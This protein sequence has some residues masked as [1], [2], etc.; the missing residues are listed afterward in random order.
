MKKPFYVIL[1]SLMIA[2]ALVPQFHSNLDSSLRLQSDSLSSSEQQAIAL[3]NGSRAYGY[4]LELENITLKHPAFR[5]AGSSGAY[6]ATNWI[7][8]QFASF[9]LNS[10]L[11]SFQFTN[12]TL[13]SRPSR[14]R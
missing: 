9:G 14:Y 12:W 3:V 5:A 8:G 11:E 2:S 4:D 1:L 13:L 6:E 7:E 10:S